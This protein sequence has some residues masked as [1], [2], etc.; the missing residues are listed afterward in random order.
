M[1]VIPNLQN[2][3]LIEQVTEE[4]SVEQE[5]PWQYLN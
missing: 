1:P 3:Y 2:L 5:Q 4:F